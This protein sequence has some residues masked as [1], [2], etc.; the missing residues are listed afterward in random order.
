MAT[1]VYKSGFISL[2]DGTLVYANPLKIKYL[3][4]FMDVFEKLKDTAN[5]EATI[6]I[7]LECAAIAMQQYY[8][9]A[10][11][12]EDIE[13]LLDINTLYK[14][15]E[16]AAGIQI[17]QQGE[18]TTQT[19]AKNEG[20]SWDEMDLATLEAELFLIGI[21]KDY[22]DL[23]SSLSLPELTATLNAKRDLDYKEKKF[24]AAIQ[25]VDIDKG[26][27]KGNEWEELKARVFSKGKAANA[28]DITALQG[29]NAAR[30]G[31]GIGLGLDYE[32][33]D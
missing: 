11:E 26:S 20:S 33:I 31:F 5:E 28:N 18:E 24:L 15:L 13:D 8:P 30:A 32:R 9:Q 7:L 19:Q 3:R 22:E 1:K 4:P 21:W 10:L 14:I 27:G 17:K 29:Q 2:V 25:G 23:E 6:E 12:Q 16:F